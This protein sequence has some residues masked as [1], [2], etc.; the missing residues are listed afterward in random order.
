MWNTSR[1]RSPSS[2]GSDPLGPSRCASP[3]MHAS[4]GGLTACSFIAASQFSSASERASGRW[5]RT[6]SSEWQY[7]RWMNS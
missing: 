3:V 4:H 1:N 6:R 2:R 5:R 7:D